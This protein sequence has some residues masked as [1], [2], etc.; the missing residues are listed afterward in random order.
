MPVMNKTVWMA[1]YTYDFSAAW[2]LPEFRPGLLYCEMGASTYEEAK[3]IFY[4]DHDPEKINCISIS[5]KRKED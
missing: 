1:K 2:D 3:A 4:R 5:L